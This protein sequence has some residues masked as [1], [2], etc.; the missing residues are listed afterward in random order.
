MNLKTATETVKNKAQRGKSE[1]SINYSWDEFK[2]NILVIRIT[3][4]EEHTKID[5]KK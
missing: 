1:Q 4:G 2:A 3:E 5:L